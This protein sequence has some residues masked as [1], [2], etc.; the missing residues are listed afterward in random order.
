MTLLKLAICGL[1]VLTIGSGAAVVAKNVVGP[2]GTQVPGLTQ[3]QGPQQVRQSLPAPGGAV[4]NGSV[5]TKTGT[6]Q[7]KPYSGPPLVEQGSVAQAVPANPC[8][9]ATKDGPFCPVAMP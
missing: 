5:V 1:M 7:P 3:A 8:A 4:H 6:T 9:R 2:M